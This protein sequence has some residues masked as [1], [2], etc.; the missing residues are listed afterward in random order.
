V[1]AIAYIRNAEDYRYVVIRKLIPAFV[2]ELIHIFLVG[3]ISLPS[4]R[5]TWQQLH[6]HCCCSLSPFQWLPW[7]SPLHCYQKGPSLLSSYDTRRSARCFPHA[8][9]SLA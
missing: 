6:S 3:E 2:F 5:L 8:L 4:P 7:S 9:P 1:R